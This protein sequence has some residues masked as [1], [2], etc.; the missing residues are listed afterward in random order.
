MH[1]SGVHVESIQSEQDT[2]RGSS[3]CRREGRFK[4]SSII[5]RS[6]PWFVRYGA[7]FGKDKIIVNWVLILNFGV[8]DLNC[9]SYVR[10]YV[11]GVEVS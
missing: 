11:V 7:C 3:Q 10:L 5:R 4:D 2:E 9:V 6:S 8:P 1:R